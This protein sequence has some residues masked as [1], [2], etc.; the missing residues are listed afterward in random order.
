MSVF[1]VPGVLTVQRLRWVLKHEAVE[2]EE[3]AA[4]EGDESDGEAEAEAEAN[5]QAEAVKEAEEEAEAD[6]GSASEGDVE[7]GERPED[8]AEGAPARVNDVSMQLDEAP[9]PAAA[10]EAAAGAAD[11][12]P[13]VRAHKAWRARWSRGRYAARKSSGQTAASGGAGGS[14]FSPARAPR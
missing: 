4:A 5:A 12:A 3:E 13:H 9:M 1:V 2:A 6:G 11:E 10:E 7:V 14:R 8:G